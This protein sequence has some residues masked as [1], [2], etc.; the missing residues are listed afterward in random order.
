M[1]V[2]V[3]GVRG[4][5]TLSEVASNPRGAVKEP[6]SWE[7][8]VRLAVPSTSGRGLSWRVKSGRRSE[9]W[10]VRASAR[11]G[12]ARDRLFVEDDVVQFVSLRFFISCSLMK[13]TR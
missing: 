11:D 4:V 6:A 8:V 10:E 7:S 9:R 1:A 13:E 3:V 2:A 12:A 5:V